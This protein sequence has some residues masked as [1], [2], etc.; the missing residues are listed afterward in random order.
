MM[1][2]YNGSL[3]AGRHFFTWNGVN[4]AGQKLSSGVYI[5]VMTMN[6]GIRFAK[7]MVMIK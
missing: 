7:K 4:R 1:E 6:T 3:E 5:Y 2:V